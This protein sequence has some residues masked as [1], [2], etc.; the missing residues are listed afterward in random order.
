MGLLEVALGLE[1]GV[2][3]FQEYHPLGP[4]R[5]VLALVAS[6]RGAIIE[7]TANKKQKEQGLQILI[8]QKLTKASPKFC[9]WTT[10]EVPWAKRYVAQSQVYVF[11]PYYR[12]KL[13]NVYIYIYIHCCILLYS[14]YHT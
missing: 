10:L 11:C 9:F 2:Q 8:L 4:M 7:A 6:R 5:E 3:D 14:T 13:F 12:V 1:A